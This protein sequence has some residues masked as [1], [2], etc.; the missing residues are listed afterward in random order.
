MADDPNALRPGAAI[1][2]YDIIRVLGAGGF[3]ITYEADSPFTGKHVAIKEFFPRGIASREGDTRIVYSA[4]DSEVVAWALKRF[5]SS[6]LDQCKLKHPNIVDVIH[7]V[8]DNGTG[9]MIMEYV[10]GHT[11]EHWLRE[12]EYLPEAEDLQP[13]MAPVLSALEYLHG[14]KMIHRDIAPDNIMVRADGTPVIIDFGSIKLIE[15]ET[16][17]RTEAGRSFAVMKQFYSPPEQIREHG[18]LDHRADIYSIGAV[19]YRAFAGRPPASAE[20]RMQKLAYGNADPFVPLAEYAPHLAPEIADAADRALSFDAAERQTSVAELRRELAWP[21]G[22]DR[23][24]FV[25]APDRA[26]EA[27]PRRSKLPWLL[28]LAG[29]AAIGIAVAF[30]N[31]LITFPKFGGEVVTAPVPAPKLDEMKEVPQMQVHTDANTPRQDAP[32][33][34]PVTYA[35]RYT[36]EVSFYRVAETNPD[37]ALTNCVPGRRTAFGAA[38]EGTALNI[39]HGGNTFVTEINADGSFDFQSGSA[40]AGGPLSR[41]MR[42]SGKITADAIDGE[43]E[44]TSDRGSCYGKLTAKAAAPGQ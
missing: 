26:A 10:E 40:E 13:L 29:I 1:A 17:L 41:K 24:M 44:S 7:Y 42:Y 30:V 32:L 28:P 36:G 39:S 9:Y 6:T 23:T 37:Q 11:L 35:S 25:P 21:D 16:Q 3:G 33:Q 12:R 43:F 14:R 5:E 8:K 38:I 19:L 34:T 20:E 22:Q 27:A 2:G 18:E 15:H 31:G 4:R